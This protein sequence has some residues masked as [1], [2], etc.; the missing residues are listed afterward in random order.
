MWKGKPL[1]A[2]FRHTE[3]RDVDLHLSRRIVSLHP[4]QHSLTDD[5]GTEYT[6]EKLLLA[7]GG[8]PRRFPFPSEETIFFR[9]V[10][11]YRRLRQLA[12]ERQSFAV[13]GGGF[14]GSELAA[15]LSMTGKQVTLIFPG[16]TISSH[17]FPA[18]LGLFLNDYYRQKGV[19]VM[20]GQHI[21]GV[22]R[23][24]EQ[25]V[26]LLKD[27]AAGSEQE[28]A[29]DAIVAGLGIDP[30]I[31]LAGAAGLA[32]DD[33]IVVDEHL[34][35]SRP[36]IYAAGDVAAFVNPAL[37]VRLR[38][39]H[40]DNANNMGRVAGEV[41]A[42]GEGVYNHLPFFYS[43]LFELGY[44]A[45][46]VLDPHMQMVMDWKEPNQEGV[47]YY[48]QGGR[49]RGVLLWNVWEQVPA[50]RRLIAEPGPFAAADLLGR[51]PE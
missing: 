12:D 3:K 15:S 2:I 40:E 29:A 25:S 24:G 47:V 23:Q 9:T 8:I 41:M 21:A 35:T 31:E 5:T 6:Y 16:D 48:L 38:V 17:L 22:R 26:L 32:I 49:V 28:V 36:D 44:E 10:E 13:I 39:E 42:G 51:L 19:N 7:T 27:K 37:G 4:R 1:P 43:D 46:G 14:I 33:G 11:D 20:P 50:A 18:A 45:V 30:A 34:R